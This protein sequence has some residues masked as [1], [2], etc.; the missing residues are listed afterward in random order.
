MKWHRLMFIAFLLSG[1]LLFLLSSGSIAAFASDIRNEC[2]S[3]VEDALD[4]SLFYQ[5][6][7]KRLIKCFDVNEDG[8]YA[9][10]YNNNVIHIY[11]SLGNFQ[12]GYR[13]VTE[14]TYGIILKENSIILYLGR[15]GTI[16]EVDKA[17]KCIY[18]ERV[19]LSKN[20]LN[21]VLYRTSK[22][23]GN[24]DYYLERDV[25]LFHGDYSRL[26][27]VDEDGIRTILYDVTEQGYWVGGFHYLLISIFPIAGVA[28]IIS[29]SKQTNKT[30]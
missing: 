17:G 25:G 14:G 13:F 4:I 20:V 9:I 6:G 30:G 3:S 8:Y 26:V 29:K 23:I 18:A 1:I 22:T 24:I 28:L 16:V 21:D 10:C 12:Y 15:S 19:S 7:E 5:E 11:D 27:K 2:A